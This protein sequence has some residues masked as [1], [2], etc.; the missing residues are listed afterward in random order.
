MK[1]TLTFFAFLIALKSCLA[2]EVDVMPTRT[3]GAYKAIALAW[4]KEQQLIGEGT[5]TRDWT[6]EQQQYILDRGKAYDDDG[7]AFEGHHMKS[8]EKYP[9]Y[10]ADLENIQFLS[11]AEHFTAHD[12]NFQIPTNGYFNPTTGET[13]D[14][15]LS[16]YQPCEIL[17]LSEP[18]ITSKNNRAQS[19]TDNIDTLTTENSGDTKAIIPTGSINTSKNGVVGTLKQ[20]AGKALEFY[21]RHRE[22][23]DPLAIF[24]VATFIEIEK[25]LKSNSNSTNQNDTDIDDDSSY[26]PVMANP[27]ENIF[28]PT[29]VIEV[30][31]SLS[32]NSNSIHQNDTNVDDDSSFDP[33]MANPN[34]DITERSSPNEHTVSAHKQRYNKIWKDKNPYPRGKKSEH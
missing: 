19:T 17:E 28:A 6:P 15:G 23:I 32:S 33:V 11:R 4:S 16:I 31:K 21:F 3:F 20:Y 27:S 29:T 12:G 13:S 1:H 2:L 8:A 14:F 26:D 10:Q 25:S 30:V 7:K 34:E 24:A 9:E 22:V 18:I 5:G